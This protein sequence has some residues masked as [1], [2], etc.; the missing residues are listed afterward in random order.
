MCL[1]QLLA[2][3]VFYPFET[4]NVKFRFFFKKDVSMLLYL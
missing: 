4:S 3:M 1:V 2:K